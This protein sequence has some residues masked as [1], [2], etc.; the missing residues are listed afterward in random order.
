MFWIVY[1]RR[2]N[3]R[4]T[5]CTFLFV[6]KFY[7]PSFPSSL[8]I[9]FHYCGNVGV[10]VCVYVMV[11]VVLLFLSAFSLLE[12]VF[13]CWFLFGV[14]PIDRQIFIQRVSTLNLFQFLF[15]RIYIFY[16]CICCTTFK[17]FSTQ[18]YNSFMHF[19]I[20]FYKSNW[21]LW[22]FCSFVSFFQSLFWCWFSRTFL[23]ASFF[24]LS[25]FKNIPFSGECL[26]FV[27]YFSLVR[28]N[29]HL[30]CLSIAAYDVHVF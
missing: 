8:S 1:R 28:M 22:L 12:F 3:A 24:L 27:L 18:I 25:F 4:A 9:S 6:S 16:Y 5:L 7:F 23:F 17:N 19:Y 15:T 11:V 14:F 13:V 21:F 20:V 30:M 2:I 26:T 29:N 10:F